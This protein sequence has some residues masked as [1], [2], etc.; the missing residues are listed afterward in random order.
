CR[1]GDEVKCSAER[2][3]INTEARRHGVPPEFYRDGQDG[4][5]GS[6]E[7]V[8]SEAG[9]P[10]LRPVAILSILSIPVKY[11]SCLSV[12]PSSVLLRPFPHRSKGWRQRKESAMA[13]NEAIRK[14]VG[15][16]FAALRAMDPAAW[17]AT[18]AED[19]V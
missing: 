1:P 9:G 19:G 7:G 10:K 2:R 14:V 17:A 5:D 3:R 18:F 12:S 4:Q 16:Y 13:S 6:E 11:S 15:E 8:P